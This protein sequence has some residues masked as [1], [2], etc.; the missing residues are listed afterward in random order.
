MNKKRILRVADAIEKAELA[1]RDIGFNMNV[2]FGRTEECSAEEGEETIDYT[3]KNCGTLACIAGWTCLL[4]E[5]LQNPNFGLAQALL[6]LDYPTANSL[7]WGDR[8]DLEKITS[9]EAVSTLRHLARSG[10]VRWDES[11]DE[12]S[13]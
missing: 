1:K 4:F 3:G 11:S 10:R 8:R 5:P 7:F 13:E 9:A 6:D 2:L 12:D